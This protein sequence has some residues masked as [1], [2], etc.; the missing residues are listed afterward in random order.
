MLSK[1]PNIINLPPINTSN[2]IQ[3]PI[4]S[5][6]QK[7]SI[8]SPTKITISILIPKIRNNFDSP[9]TNSCT[10]EGEVSAPPTSSK[11]EIRT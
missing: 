3:R 8:N 5:M 10:K 7:N 1:P 6:N 2:R 4:S 11:S 9:P